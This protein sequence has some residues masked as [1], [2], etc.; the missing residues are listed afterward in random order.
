MK[1]EIASG[2]SAGVCFI[3]DAL[4]QRSL[5]FAN[6]LPVEASVDDDVVKFSGG[7]APN[8]DGIRVDEVHC[9]VKTVAR[10]I[11][12]SCSK[13]VVHADGDARRCRTPN[14]A[15]ALEGDALLN[16]AGVFRVENQKLNALGS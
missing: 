4:L 16:F 6:A 7:F 9:V 14:V 8:T 5:G 11:G 13:G 3:D 2:E 15:L 1:F 12:A 10:A